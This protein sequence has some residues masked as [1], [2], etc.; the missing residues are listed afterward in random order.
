[1][2]EDD[3]GIGLLKKLSGNIEIGE[4]CENVSELPAEDEVIL[5]DQKLDQVLGFGKN[6]SVICKGIHK[7]S[8]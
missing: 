7:V 1:M 5:G 8:H 2:L 3:Q 6:D 4:D